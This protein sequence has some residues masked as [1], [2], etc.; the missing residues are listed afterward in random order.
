[1]EI[2]IVRLDCILLFY[3]RQP[4]IPLNLNNSMSLIDDLNN[5]YLN[6]NKFRVL[7]GKI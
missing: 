5:Y 2:S 4:T 7:R 6:P 3:K 1:M